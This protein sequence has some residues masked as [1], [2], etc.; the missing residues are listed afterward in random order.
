LHA[1]AAPLHR[2]VGWKDPQVRWAALTALARRRHDGDLCVL[3]RCALESSDDELRVATIEVAR[4]ERLRA[5]DDVVD[6]VAT[7]RGEGAATRAAARLA[8]IWCDLTSGADAVAGRAASALA[9]LWGTFE[10]DRRQQ[11]LKELGG[12]PTSVL[13]A[14]TEGLRVFHR[15]CRRA[16]LPA[17]FAALLARAA[18]PR[19]REWLLDRLAVADESQR[20]VISVA[21]AGVAPDALLGSHDGV[22]Q[23]RLVARAVRDGVLFYADGWRSRSGEW[24]PYPRH[25]QRTPPAESPT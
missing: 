15:S 2:F 16:R 12:L 6:A 14:V 20:A 18:S 24:H 8:R 7:R 5:F 9:A 23:A 3:R 4:K 1:V 25:G 10:D 19:D 21:L 17:A 13:E 22:L 11:L